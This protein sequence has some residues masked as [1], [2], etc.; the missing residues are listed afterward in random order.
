M[1][2]NGSVVFLSL[3]NHIIL[4]VWLLYFV[5]CDIVLNESY[6]KR[7]IFIFIVIVNILFVYDYS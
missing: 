1:I 5:V 2:Q 4:Q 7:T 3:Q 6:L